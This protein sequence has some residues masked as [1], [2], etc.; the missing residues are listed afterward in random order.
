MF[1]LAILVGNA[2]RR[3]G[4]Y[5]PADAAAPRA[6]S[7]AWNGGLSQCSV[8]VPSGCIRN[9]LAVPTNGRVRS[10][11]GTVGSR[12]PGWCAMREQTLGDVGQRAASARRETPRRS[13]AA[14]LVIWRCEFP[15]RS[16]SALVLCVMPGGLDG[17]GA[18]RT[19]QGAANNFSDTQDALA[20]C[21]APCSRSSRCY[22]VRTAQAVSFGL[23]PG[24]WQALRTFGHR[25]CDR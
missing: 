13:S 11:A 1:P 12:G 18:D 24:P 16:V 3:A 15:G 20:Q 25:F 7:G 14:R 17:R 5:A 19:P 21:V 22:R 8:R 9:M 10:G 6:S 23:D 2:D 4:L